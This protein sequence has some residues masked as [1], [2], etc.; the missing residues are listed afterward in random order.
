LRLFLPEAKNALDPL[1]GK[2]LIP[3][4]ILSG[5]EVADF[6]QNLNVLFKIMTRADTYGNSNF[7]YPVRVAIIKNEALI[8]V[9]IPSPIAL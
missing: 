6:S 2:S 7:V 5:K 8:Y 3:K 9:R 4:L 1:P